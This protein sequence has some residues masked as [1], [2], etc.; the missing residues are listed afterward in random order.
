MAITPTPVDT[1]GVLKAHAASLLVLA[2]TVLTAISSVVSWRD[3]DNVAQ[4]VTIAIQAATVYGLGLSSGK[5][6]GALKVGSAAALT[7]VSLIVPLIISGG[8]SPQN[9][10]LI[11][12]AGLNAVAAQIGVSIR[13]RDVQGSY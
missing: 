9:V 8:W 13:V 3:A 4:F 2:I 10:V 5:W 11:A 1:G 12:L 6:A 7:V